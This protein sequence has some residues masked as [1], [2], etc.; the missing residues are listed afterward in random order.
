EN[1]LL[2]LIDPD[3]PQQRLSA[4]KTAPELAATAGL[5]LNRTQRNLNYFAS[6]AV[7]ILEQLSSG[8]YRLAHERLIPALESLAGE[9]LAAAEQAKRLLNERYRTWQKAKRWKFLLSGNELRSV[10]KYRSHFQ[11]DI[12][13]EQVHY[14]RKSNRKRYLTISLGIAAVLILIL[15]QPFNNKI[16]DPVRWKQRIKTLELEFVPVKGDTFE[17]G[18]L[19]GNGDKDEKPVHKVLLSNFEISRYEITNEQYCYFLKSQNKSELEKITWRDF[20]CRIDDN[21]EVEEKYKNHPVTGITYKGASAFCKWLG[22]RLPT[23]AQWEYAA[24]GGHKSNGYEYSGADSVD[25]DSVAWYN[26]NSDGTTHPVGKKNP[27]ELGLYDMSGNVWEWCYDWYD[28]YYYKECFKKEVVVDPDGPKNANFR[29]LRGGSWFNDASNV[30]CANRYD[31][32]P[33]SSHYDI[34]F[35]CVR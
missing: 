8:S 25:V 13:P 29:V 6:Q 21:F 9:L 15:W 17:M 19:W 28:E 27:N 16:I 10:L 33:N 22:A 31:Y 14:I 18:D 32:G 4:G 2:A 24:R 35:R 1:A 23:E 20:G 26:Y 7:R 5:P 11:N 12:S 3:N 34:G 30:R